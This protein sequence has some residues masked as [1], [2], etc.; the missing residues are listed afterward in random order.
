LKQEKDLTP[1]QAVKL[2]ALTRKMEIANADA[3]FL[4]VA[5]GVLAAAS[6][7]G[8]AYGFV[9][10]HKQIQPILDETAKTQLEIA[11]LQLAKMRAEQGA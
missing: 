11:K 4:G 3:K 6:I 1:V 5:C 8:M 2:A 9:K 7:L 10:W